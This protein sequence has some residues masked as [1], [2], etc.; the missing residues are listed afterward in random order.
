MNKPICTFHYITNSIT[1]LQ[2]IWEQREIVL[3]RRTSVER[4]VEWIS[5]KVFTLHFIWYF[6]DL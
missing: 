6:L 4:Q 2:K 3:V 1:S 5:L